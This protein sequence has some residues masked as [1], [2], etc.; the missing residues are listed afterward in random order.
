[1]VTIYTE[2][3]WHIKGAFNLFQQDFSKLEDAR[4]IHD[5][6]VTEAGK[7]LIFTSVPY[8]LSLIHEVPSFECDTTFKRV[9]SAD[10]NEWEM[11][12]YYPPAQ[13][14]E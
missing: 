10:I 2:T 12:I 7:L 1:M 8:L 6:I 3:Y 9:K 13:R 14:G 4:Y 5:V 11:V